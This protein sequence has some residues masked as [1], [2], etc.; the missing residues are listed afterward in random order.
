MFTNFHI[1]KGDQ[2]YVWK[3]LECSSLYLDLRSFMQ[4]IAVIIPFSRDDTFHSV[5][6]VRSAQIAVST[7]EKLD[8]RN[9]CGQSEYPSYDHATWSSMRLGDT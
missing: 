5:G 3:V 1:N 8:G 4:L 2:S 6:D 9:C 7:N